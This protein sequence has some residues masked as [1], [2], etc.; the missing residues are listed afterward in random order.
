MKDQ[1][2]KDCEKAQTTLKQVKDEMA[3][4]NSAEAAGNSTAKVN[5]QYR[6]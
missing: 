2:K 5:N 3:K 4:R 6:A 1:F